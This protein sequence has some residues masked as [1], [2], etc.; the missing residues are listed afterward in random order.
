[1]A[2]AKK[3]VTKTGAQSITIK[4]LSTAADIDAV[5]NMSEK[6]K[7]ALKTLFAASRNATA[8]ELAALRA[9]DK[10]AT[11]TVSKKAPAKKAEVLAKDVSTSPKLTK[12]EKAAKKLAEL[13][14][15]EL[16]YRATSVLVPI[17]FGN[18]DAEKVM[19]NRQLRAEE[20]L[21]IMFIGSTPGGAS[22]KDIRVN[23]HINSG[24]DR[25][26]A[27]LVGFWGMSSLTGSKLGKFVG[28][29]AKLKT[30]QERDSQKMVLTAKGQKIF[31]TARRSILDGFEPK[32][33]LKHRYF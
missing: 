12:E 28:D 16:L 1:M 29:R 22:E 25:R 24:F 10:V 14:R 15:N 2:T 33:A 8:E 26:E 11:K 3:A 9:E 27:M 31:D 7:K 32:R 21:C 19:K 4:H 13:E 23:L 6:H 17:W 30:D 5:Q 20:A 18:A